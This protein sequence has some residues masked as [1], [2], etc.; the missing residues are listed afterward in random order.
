MH[1]NQK[2]LALIDRIL[3]GDPYAYRA[4]I[5]RHKEYAFTIAYRILGNR[6]DA[7]EITQDAFMSAFRAFQQF[8]R[9]SKFTTWFYRIVFNAALG[10][11]RKNKMA[12]EQIEDFKLSKLGMAESAEGIKHQ[13]QKVYIQKSLNKLPADDVSLITLF[14]LKEFSLEEI[15]GITGIAANTAKVKLFRARKRLAEELN[16]LLKNEAHNLL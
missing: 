13:E 15:E 16:Q 7:E 14:Y 9:E 10:H 5:N 6:E 1:D 11:K 2:D 3:T 8:N 4:L 12:T